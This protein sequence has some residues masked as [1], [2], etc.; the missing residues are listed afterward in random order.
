MLRF[1][2]ARVT[3]MLVMALL[4]TLGGVPDYEYRSGRSRAGAAWRP[5]RVRSGICC[6]MA[7]RLRPRSTVVGAIL[8]LPEGLSHG[9][10][11]NSIHSQRPVLDD[12]EEYT[13]A[14][15]ELGTVAFILT[16]IVGIPLGILAAVK[17]DSWIDHLAR[18]VS[19]LG[20]SSPTF[21]LAFILL[22]VFYGYFQIAP[23]PGRLDPDR[24]A[25]A[26]RH[27]LLPDRF[28]AGRRL[29]YVSGRRGTSGPAVDRAGRRNNRADHTHDTGK[30][31]GSHPAGLCANEPR[32][33][34]ARTERDPWPR[35]A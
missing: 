19:L 31:A 15:L 29:G 32:E 27:R 2:V 16:L 12:I 9:D 33:R 20:V 3:T 4:A 21:W 8:D 1:L 5:S 7:A 6:A 26:D 22:A 13:P 14:T 34:P 17:R 30:H 11:G 25:T 24:V 23:G 28:R 10:L 18:V 35:A